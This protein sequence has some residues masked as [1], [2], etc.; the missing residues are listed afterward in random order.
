[1]MK[2]KKWSEVYNF[3]RYRMEIFT[4]KCKGI[5]M[6]QDISEETHWLVQMSEFIEPKTEIFFLERIGDSNKY[7][8]TRYVRKD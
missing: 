6:Y 8:L 1:M 4:G 5:Y 2:Y 7:D 3:T